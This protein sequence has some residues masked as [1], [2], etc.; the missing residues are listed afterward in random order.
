MLA[1]RW[2]QTDALHY[3]FTFLNCGP[4]RQD[5]PYLRSERDYPFKLGADIAADGKR[6]PIRETW[7]PAVSA[8]ITSCWS[9]DASLRPSLPRVM[10]MLELIIGGTQ[11]MI[12][13]AEIPALAPPE[14]DYNEHLAP[15]ALWR[16]FEIKPSSLDVGDVLGHG[17]YSRVHKCTFRN[18]PA[19]LKMFRNATEEKALKEIEITFSMRHPNI[20]GIYAW[21]RERGEMMT[22]VGMVIELAEGGDLMDLYT[23]KKEGRAYSFKAAL[24]IVAG[25]AKGL[26]HMHAMP[27]PVVHRDI[28][29]ANIMIMG[30][31]ITGK[32]ADCGESRRVDLESTMTKTGTPLWAAVS[33]E[34]GGRGDAFPLCCETLSAC[35]LQQ[36]TPNVLYVARA[37]RGQA[38]QRGCRYVLF[39]CRA[40]RDCRC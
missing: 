19:V 9:N 13:S 12:T 28:K 10:A 29:S 38:L 24:K 37:A 40:V 23:E 18:K 32:V 33:R 26:A 7:N 25:A 36:L 5:L 35:S 30:D 16:K 14:K 39:W 8:L 22:Q 15:G 20:I 6:P 2:S 21:L 4:Q 17:S 1:R 34:G 3:S 27:A 31:G 11:G